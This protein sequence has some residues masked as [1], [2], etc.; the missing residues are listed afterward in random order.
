MHARLL[1]CSLRAST[2]PSCRAAHGI[3]ECKVFASQG[4]HIREAHLSLVTSK[5]ACWGQGFIRLSSAQTM[6]EKCRPKNRTPCHAHEERR[7]PD[8]TILC[9]MAVIKMP[10]SQP[11]GR[12][13]ELAA[14]GEGVDGVCGCCL[15]GGV[16][17][18]G[19]HTRS[20]Y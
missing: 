19:M 6:G 1:I 9:Q 4:V 11:V 13:L 12:H 16:G 8:D 15:V 18:G 14:R 2:P 10:S 5:G 3:R 20:W 7:S 17:W